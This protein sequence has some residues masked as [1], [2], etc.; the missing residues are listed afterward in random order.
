MDA[1]P[2][3]PRMQSPSTA[4]TVAFV[5]LVLGLVLLLV[6]AANRPATRG[7]VP[8][9]SRRWG[10]RTAVL[11]LVWLALSGAV[12]ASGVL[13]TKM[14]PPPAL[15]YAFVCL[16]VAAATAYSTLGTRLVSAVPIAWLIGFQSFRLPLELVLHAWWK[17]GV[18]PIQMTFAGQNLDIVSGVSALGLGIWAAVGRVPRSIVLSFNLLGLGLL[19][20]VMT[21]AILSAPTPVRVYMNDPPVLLPFNFPY[22]WIIPWCVGGALFGHLLVFRW[23]QRAPAAP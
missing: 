16:G 21:I 18:L 2:D 22:A 9:R 11:A 10:R 4:T 23:L 7:E 15:L 20:N 8:A 14:L 3:I 12:P 13:A 19:I 5:A 17:E 6:I 1:L